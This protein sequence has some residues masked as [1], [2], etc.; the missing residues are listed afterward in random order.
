MAPLHR[1][2]RK[3]SSPEYPEGMEPA[4]H[5][6]LVGQGLGKPPLDDAE[7]LFSLS[8]PVPSFDVTPTGVQGTVVRYIPNNLL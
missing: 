8:R 3:D 1:P 2:C 7:A 4:S 5:R 6:P